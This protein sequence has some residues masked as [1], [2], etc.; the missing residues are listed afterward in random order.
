MRRPAVFGRAGGPVVAGRQI[1]RLA[2][3]L[4]TRRAARR[5]RQFGG[6][7]LAMSLLLWLALSWL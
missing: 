1:V 4:A 6:L 7:V 5:V 2:R 3:R